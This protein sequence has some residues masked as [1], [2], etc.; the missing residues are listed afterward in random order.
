LGSAVHPRRSTRAVR[1]LE[2]GGAA[3]TRCGDARSASLPFRSASAPPGGQGKGSRSPPPSCA[4]LR[5][6]GSLRQ[7]GG[8]D[9]WLARTTPLT[10]SRIAVSVLAALA[11][12]S[13]TRCADRAALCSG[14]PG[15]RPKNCTERWNARR[16]AL[17]THHHTGSRFHSGPPS[18]LTLGYRSSDGHGRPGR[19][20]TAAGD[21]CP[22]APIMRA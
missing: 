15:R 16:V 13:A 9:R 17:R 7:H 22:A 12:N 10:A 4:A 19:A 3:A 1:C 8:C 5:S 20:S 21:L 11:L 2:S 6:R 18:G 14:G